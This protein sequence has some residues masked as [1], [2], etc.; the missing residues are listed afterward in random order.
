MYTRWGYPRC[1]SAILPENVRFSPLCTWDIAAVWSEP[2]SQTIRRAVEPLIPARMYTELTPFLERTSCALPEKTT[3]VPIRLGS[4]KVFPSPAKWNS[5]VALMGVGP[6][7]GTFVACTLVL[8]G[9][10]VGVGAGASV[11]C[12]L[13]LVGVASSASAVGVAGGVAIASRVADM[14]ASTRWASMVAETPASI[15]S[16]SEAESV[17]SVQPGN[18][19]A[20]SSRAAT[21]S[22]GI[23]EIKMRWI[24][25]FYS[26]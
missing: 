15:F 26:C 16:A 6:G 7:A 2:D 5:T 17:D 10:A 21:R 8:V 3:G 22:R 12:T 11:D 20:D 18:A 14:E 1:P 19:S 4:L 24:T 9:V 13:V 23:K 25:T